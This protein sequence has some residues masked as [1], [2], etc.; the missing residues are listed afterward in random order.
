MGQVA[1]SP[2]QVAAREFCLE[3]NLCKF[4]LYLCQLAREVGRFVR[5]TGQGVEVCWK[6]N[7][8]GTERE[9]SGTARSMS[10]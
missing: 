8:E 4:G 9:R 2:V 5:D 1:G 6:H 10:D 7:T 3:G